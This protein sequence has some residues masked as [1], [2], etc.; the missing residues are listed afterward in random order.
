[1]G[2]RVL[3][4]SGRN[5]ALKDEQLDVLKDKGHTK[6]HEKLGGNKT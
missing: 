1:M 4:R 6:N 2:R 5:H 3:E